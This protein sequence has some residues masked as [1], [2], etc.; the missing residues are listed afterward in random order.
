MGGGGKGE[1]GK[2][3]GEAG[4]V[5]GGLTGIGAPGVGPQPGSGYSCPCTVR[6]AT[7]GERAMEE[8]CRGSRG[9]ECV[10]VARS[11]ERVSNWKGSGM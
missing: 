2:E 1:G 5:P 10:Y 11:G 8:W 3:R 9:R 4:W 6:C 7:A